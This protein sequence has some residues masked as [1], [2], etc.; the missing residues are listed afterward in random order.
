M[1]ESRRL[2]IRKNGNNTII[3][4]IR[5]LRL[6]LCIFFFLLGKLGGSEYFWL[7]QRVPRLFVPRLGSGNVR[8]CR[9]ETLFSPLGDV[10]FVSQEEHEFE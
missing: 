9:P 1:S 3:V 10:L 6:H 4:Y 8:Y 5:T 7:S 2:R